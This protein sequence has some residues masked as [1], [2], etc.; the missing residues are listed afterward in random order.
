MGMAMPPCADKYID[1]GCGG[2]ASRLPLGKG[3]RAVCPKQREDG[4]KAK[5]WE[6]GKHHGV[7]YVRCLQILKAVKGGFQHFT[8]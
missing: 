4:S 6:T 2:F 8:Q 3:L 7:G 1:M 5:Q